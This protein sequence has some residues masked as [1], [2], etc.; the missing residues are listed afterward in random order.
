MLLLNQTTVIKP[1]NVRELDFYQNIPSDIQ[2]FI[3]KYKGNFNINFYMIFILRIYTKVIKKENNI[4]L[5][6]CMK[7]TENR[8]IRVYFLVYN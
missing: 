5:Y 2:M 4:N 3:P 6:K 7:M 1:L 8:F